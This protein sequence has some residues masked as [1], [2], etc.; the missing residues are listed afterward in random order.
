MPV[1]PPPNRSARRNPG[2]QPPALSDSEFRRLGR[3][4]VEMAADQLAD[5]RQRK[6]V[7]TVL[8][9]EENMVRDQP[10]PEQGLEPDEILDFISR[11]VLPYPLGNDHPRFFGWVNSPPAPMGVVAD[12]LA[13][14]MNAP[15]G[16]LYSGTR[17]E[18]CV[19]RWL[20]EMIGFPTEGSHGTLLSGGS[21]ANLSALAAARYWAA[22]RDSWDIRAEGLQGGRATLV[23]YTSAEGHACIRKS[24]ELL[25]LGANNLRMVP[26][27]G[28]FR[29]RL[30]ALG[31]AVEAD[32]SAGR[33]PF[34]VIASAGTVNTGA[35]DPLAELAEFCAAHELWFHID[36]AYGAFGVLDPEKAP[37]YRGMERADSVALDPHKW[38]SVPIESGWLLVRDA[39]L[40]R[41]T[42]HVQ[43]PYLRLAENGEADATPEPY[44]YGF[45]LTRGFRGLKAWATICHRGRAGVART[46]VGHNALARY[47]AAAVEAAPDLELMA[48][49][50]LSIVCYRYVPSGWTGDDHGLDA[51][52][53]AIVETLNHEGEVFFTPTV[54]NGATVLRATIIH[55]DTGEADLDFLVDSV[56]RP[57]ATLYGQEK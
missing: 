50:S 21:M 17:L 16:G 45:E 42:F 27:D 13:S 9:N 8:E 29:I 55:Y 43:P 2:G 7:P 46:I 56:R 32:L 35:I 4:A 18:E 12:L 37:L 54:L 22:R 51:L 30:D 26:V 38:L 6:V 57:G 23:A 36:G 19:S 11:Y 10:L 31:E 41:E 33:K 20:M 3:R 48:P 40:L 47:L 25:G 1:P 5:V 53:R 14:I 49:V 15:Y 44:E 24:M 34:C 28:D 39:E 52:N